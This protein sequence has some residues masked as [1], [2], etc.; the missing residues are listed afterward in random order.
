MAIGN[1]KDAMQYAAQNPDSD[2]AKNLESLLASGSLDQEAKKYGINTAVFK[3]DDQKVAPDVAKAPE[4]TNATS[5]AKTIV[6]GLGAGLGASLPLMAI[7]Y[8]G[9]KALQSFDNPDE[10]QAVL[11]GLTPR[12]AAD[13]LAKAGSLE[14]QY[15]TTLDAQKNPNLYKASEI[16]GTALGL[17]DVPVAAGRAVIKNAPKVINT[18][19]EVATSAKGGAEIIKDVLE[20]VAR[21]PGNIKT[22]LAQKAGDVAEIKTLTS[23]TAQNAV[24]GGIDIKD[25]RQLPDVV[26]NSTSRELIDSVKRL[27][28]GDRNADPVAIVG[29]PLTQAFK[30]LSLKANTIGAD[31]GK[32]SKEI[33]K[34]D[35]L[36]VG[37]SVLKRLQ[38]VKGLE[39]LK[40]NPE[41]KLDFSETV[42]ANFPESIKNIESVYN[43][44]LAT[45]NQANNGVKLHLYRQGLFE[46]LGGKKKALA[47]LTS[48][49]E[50][51]INAIR[52]GIGDAIETVS[53]KYKELSTQYAQLT[54]PLNK[55]KK[56]LKAADPGITEAEMDLTSGLLS[57]RLT[58]LASSN[59]QIRALLNEVGQ[60]TGNPE[61]RDT[62]MKSQDLYNILNRYYDI[63]P[64][65]GYQKLTETAQAGSSAYE[66]IAGAVKNLAGKTDI[67][68]QKALEDFLNELLNATK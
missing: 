22:N 36:S 62:I 44:T 52:G 15:A 64:Q 53:P 58:S 3:S 37:D 57:R 16:T 38:G 59:P 8:L 24:Y 42:I 49:D 21:I 5:K 26:N 66:A 43:K 45:T 4:P 51:A 12:Q 40:L 20:P 18:A 68:R 63:A 23:K 1:L 39:G 17:A 32:V 33:G 47:N 11:G 34:V 10:P 67:V 54:E 65:T 9:E 31:L 13:N 14:G 2:F 48:T 27:A 25:V 30:D 6:G 55:L 50:N 7:E 19:K 28:A 46:D 60:A 41:G 35:P 29:K 56:A 61:L